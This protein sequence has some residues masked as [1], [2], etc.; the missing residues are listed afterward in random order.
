MCGP[1][2][3]MT[4]GSSGKNRELSVLLYHIG[5]ISAYLTIASFFGIIPALSNSFQLQSLVAV[6]AGGL[7]IILAL[8]PKLLSF[9]EKRGFSVFNK[10]F[11]FKN[12]LAESFKKNK[13]EYSLY[14]G[15]LNGFIPCGMVY[16]AAIGAMA[17]SSFL[18]S[19]IFMFFFGIGTLP[20][21]AAFQLTAGKLGSFFGK[22]IP[23]VRTVALVLIG[24]WM[25]FKGIDNYNYEIQQPKEGESFQV[26]AHPGLISNVAE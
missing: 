21:M 22:Y 17:Q 26:C 16:M 15:F 1:I 10:L 23:V 5:K 14:F 18:N 2:A 12:K 19:L 25:I 9:I 11:S 6:F 20:L 13:K 4:P 8:L 3:M 7:I 24:S